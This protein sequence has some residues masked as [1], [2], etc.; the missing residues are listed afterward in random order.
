MNYYWTDDTR[1][2][3]KV[4]DGTLSETA[5][6]PRVLTDRDASWALIPFDQVQ[7]EPVADYQLI[8]DLR[9]KRDRMLRESDWTQ[10]NDAP[11]DRDAWA[12]YRQALRDLPQQ[13]GF[14][15]DVGWP[16]V[17]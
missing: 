13:E 1:R 12:V 6:A 2:A 11:V 8:Q 4:I 5:E 7:S 16:E 3:V 17:G 14:P 15:E 9:Q 10:L